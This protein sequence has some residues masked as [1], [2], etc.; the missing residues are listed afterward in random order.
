VATVCSGMVCA[1]QRLDASA[2]AQ[3]STATTSSVS[4]GAAD[5]RWRRQGLPPCKL[6]W[7][8]SSSDAAEVSHRRAVAVARV[9]HGHTA[10]KVE[11]ARRHT[12]GGHGRRRQGSG[13]EDRW[14]SSG[15]VAV[16]KKGFPPLPLTCG[17][18]RRPTDGIHPSNGEG[19]RK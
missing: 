14:P 3:D 8:C 11:L 1:W 4:G 15:G 6:S 10:A 5:G 16:R 2:T 12:Y 9:G 18:H 13:E 19:R 7:L 17:A